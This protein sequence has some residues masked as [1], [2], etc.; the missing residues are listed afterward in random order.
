MYNRVTV[1]ITAN[2]LIAN[3]AVVFSGCMNAIIN[4]FIFPHIGWWA[5]YIR[6]LADDRIMVVLFLFILFE[7]ANANGRKAIMF[8]CLIKYM[9]FSLNGYD[10]II[11]PEI[12]Y[13]HIHNGII[14]LFLNDI[15][16]LLM[17]K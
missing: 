10:N 7:T 17:E 16:Q 1:I 4:L 8:I 5:K 13:A 14:P 3:S 9:M 12:M 6:L 11:M 15:L 2:V